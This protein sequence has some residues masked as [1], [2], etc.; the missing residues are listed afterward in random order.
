[1][2]NIIIRRTNR[3][4]NCETALVCRAQSMMSSVFLL[5][6]PGPSS[7]RVICTF[8]FNRTV[9]L[10]RWLSLFK[11][12]F[13]NSF[14]LY[15][16]LNWTCVLHQHKKGSIISKP[17]F[18]ERQDF[19][20]FSGHSTKKLHSSIIPHSNQDMAIFRIKMMSTSEKHRISP[21]S[22][23]LRRFKEHNL[24]KSTTVDCAIYLAFSLFSSYF[25]RGYI[26]FIKKVVCL[27]PG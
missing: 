19:S 3:D 22:K 8:T 4:R 11:L 10:I 9:L 18:W 7:T 13:G 12:L 25:G 27:C 15:Q 21:I 6:D 16:V 17:A 1:M 26:H 23:L 5:W 2:L 24:L 20:V 14:W